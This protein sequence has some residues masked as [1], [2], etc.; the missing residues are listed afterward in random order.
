LIDHLIFR[1]W[2]RSAP[3]FSLL[4]SSPLVEA[5]TPAE[6][7][8]L[9]KFKEDYLQRA[10]TE[11]SSDS[12]DTSTLEI[13]NVPIAEE[14][15]RVDVIIVKFL[16]AKYPTHKRQINSVVTSFFPRHTHNL[17]RL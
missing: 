8:A 3:N 13:W 17:S 16:R 15:P 7:E 11:A 5:F 12:P 6:R 14:S 1:N 9:S 4:M 2:K 10:L